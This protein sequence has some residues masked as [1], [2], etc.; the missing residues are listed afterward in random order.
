MTG[1]FFLVPI[2]IAL[3]LVGLL[4]FIWTLKDGQYDDLAGAAERIL[5]DDGDRPLR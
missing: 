2:A 1:F 4:T 5:H 3:G